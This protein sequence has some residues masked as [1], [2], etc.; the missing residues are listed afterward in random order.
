MFKVY[1][2][3]REYMKQKQLL[4]LASI[5]LRDYYVMSNKQ[6]QEKVRTGAELAYDTNDFI[7]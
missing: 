2:K 7:N 6:V 5:F 4:S 3:C 1:E